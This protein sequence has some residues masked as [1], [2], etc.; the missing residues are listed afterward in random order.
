MFE[1]ASDADLVTLMGE[2]AREE[3]AAMGRRLSLV[4]ELCARRH[5]ET[6]PPSATAPRPTP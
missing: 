6:K 3:S 4:G 2:E 5:P 1:E